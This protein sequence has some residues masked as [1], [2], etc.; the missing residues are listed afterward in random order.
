MI[1]NMLFCLQIQDRRQLLLMVAEDAKSIISESKVR[2]LD[3][4]EDDCYLA[5]SDIYRIM[6]T[7]AKAGSKKVLFPL[8]APKIL[9]Y[10]SNLNRIPREQLTR[11][12]QRYID[13][14]KAEELDDRE[15]K[16]SVGSNLALKPAAQPDLTAKNSEPKIVEL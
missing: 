2:L 11:Q 4:S 14:L 5:L 13:R 7:P 10:L 1:L 6:S 8:A 9:F 15:F 12:L 16:G 3:A